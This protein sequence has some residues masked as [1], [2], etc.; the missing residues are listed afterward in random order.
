M[1]QQQQ[2]SETTSPFN[3]REMGI[4]LNALA[5]EDAIK[6]FSAAKDGINTSTR[7][8]REL[9]L[10]QKRY[11][12]RLKELIEAGLIEKRDNIY[13]HTTLGALCHSLG[14][15]FNTILN[16]RDRLDLA[17]RLNRTKNIS[18]EETEQILQALSGKGI[19][20]SL[21]VADLMQ[22][23]KMLDNYEALVAELVDRINKAEK[24]V[25]LASYYHDSRAVEAILRASERDVQLAF[26]SGGERS[27]M[28]R[29]QVLRMMLSPKIAKIY[30]T[31]LDGKIR[32]RQAEKLPYSFCV[33]DEKLVII[34]LTNPVTND[35]YLGFSIKSETLGQ[36]LAETFETMFRKGKENPILNLLKE[37]SA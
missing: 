21:K 12:T 16:Q 25:C 15:T 2:L 6:I 32:M 18:L 10:T 13:Q 33:V 22:P 5:N 1:T 20:G 19:I 31:F 9:G 28:E 36:R 34:E 30:A 37:K 3:I 8:I 4:I 7:T 23:V 17:D 14:E 29:L 24:S 27:V 35:F 26:L 11:Y